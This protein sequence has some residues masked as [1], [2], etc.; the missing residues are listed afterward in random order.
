[1]R[2][3]IRSGVSVSVSHTIRSVREFYRL[4]CLT[5]KRHGL[6]PQP[7]YFFEAIYEHIIK[8]RKGHV[9]LAFYDNKPIAGSVFFHF[10][11]QAVY[12]YGASDAHYSQYRAN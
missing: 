11:K 2:R 12:K 9:V 3:A 1:M 8:C 10:R 5:R 6:P 4:N 7:W